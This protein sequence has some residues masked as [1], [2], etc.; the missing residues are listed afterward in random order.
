MI[1]YSGPS[2]LD[3]QP[4]VAIATGLDS[5]TENNKTGDMIQVW[6]L[7]QSMAPHHAVAMGADSSVCGNCSKRRGKG[8]DCYVI[9]FQAPLGG[10]TAWQNP[11]NC[12]ICCPKPTSSFPP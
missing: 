3:G 10:W 8:G 11:Q 2:K 5:P 7:L 1:I 9:P 6:I 4:I 12:T